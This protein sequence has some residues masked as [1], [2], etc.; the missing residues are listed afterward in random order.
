MNSFLKKT[1][2]DFWHS[3]LELNPATASVG[4]QTGVS[5]PGGLGATLVEVHTT[6]RLLEP[7][8]VDT[9]FTSKFLSGNFFLTNQSKQTFFPIYTI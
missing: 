4:G 2:S 9:R 6:Q 7:A 1:E 5:P 3:Y 8:I